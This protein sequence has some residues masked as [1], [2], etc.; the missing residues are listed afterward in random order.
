M[1]LLGHSNNHVLT[2]PSTTNLQTTK[3]E[4]SPHLDAY[5]EEEERAR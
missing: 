3:E 1:H 4:D 2:H 5:V